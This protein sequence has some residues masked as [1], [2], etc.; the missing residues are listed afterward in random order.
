[1][2]PTEGAHVTLIAPAA[3]LAVILS[4]AAAVIV[5]DPAPMLVWFVALAPLAW[6]AAR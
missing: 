2:H 3:M 4:I 6:K 1:M 5:H